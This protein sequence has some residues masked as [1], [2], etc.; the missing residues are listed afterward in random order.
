MRNDSP[1]DDIKESQQNKRV[2]PQKNT[3]RMN[4]LNYKIVDRKCRKYHNPKTVVGKYARGFFPVKRQ[5]CDEA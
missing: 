2:K 5:Q 3:R 4:I 1:P